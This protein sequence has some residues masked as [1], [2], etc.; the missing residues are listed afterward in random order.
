MLGGQEVWLD[1]LKKVN[2]CTEGSCG[3]PEGESKEVRV[4]MAPVCGVRY[5]ER[6]WASV[7]HQGFAELR[8]GGEMVRGGMVVGIWQLERRRIW[9]WVEHSS[10]CGG[11]VGGAECLRVDKASPVVGSVRYAI[12]N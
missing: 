6:S 12:S 9:P 3:K 7:V 11:Y 10:Q 4:V 2:W 5:K 1:G 8:R